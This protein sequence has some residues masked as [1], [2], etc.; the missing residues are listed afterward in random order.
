MAVEPQQAGRAATIMCGQLH[1]LTGDMMAGIT[2][3]QLTRA[4]NMLKSFLVMGTEARMIA[5]EGECW[6]FFFPPLRWERCEMGKMDE[7]ELTLDL[8]RQF[9]TQ[10]FKESA[11]LM[12]SKVDDVTKADVHR[13]ATRLFRPDSRK[14]PLNAGIGSGEPTI[15]AIGKNVEGLGDVRSILRKWDLGAKQ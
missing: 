14:T 15:V 8:G 1:A 11:A 13:V 5:A 10:G 3:E 12:C 2:Q 7:T 6:S 4:K 9:L